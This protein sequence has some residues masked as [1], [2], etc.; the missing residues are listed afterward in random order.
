[1]QFIE[2]QKSH[3]KQVRVFDSDLVPA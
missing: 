2:E 1:L 3:W